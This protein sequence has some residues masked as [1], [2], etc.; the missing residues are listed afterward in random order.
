MIEKILNYIN[1]LNKFIIYSF[2]FQEVHDL[3]KKTVLKPTQVNWL[4]KLRRAKEV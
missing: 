4:N 2:S 1:I 3:I